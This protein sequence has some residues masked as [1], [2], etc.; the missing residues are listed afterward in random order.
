MAGCPA[1]RLE[2]G[3]LRKYL[4]GGR[5]SAPSAICG[6]LFPADLLIAAHIKR[7]SDCTDGQRRLYA[8]NLMTA[9]AFGCDDLIRAGDGVNESA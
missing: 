1:V 7:R 2:Q 5:E 8:T 3:I 4:I 9:C 6:E